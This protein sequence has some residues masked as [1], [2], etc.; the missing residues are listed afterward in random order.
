MISVAPHTLTS[1]HRDAS[2]GMLSVAMAA[3]GRT[4]MLSPS[5]NVRVV[6]H[7]QVGAESRRRHAQQ[8][9]KLK[10][11]GCGVSVLVQAPLLT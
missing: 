10:P 8:Q 5:T 11:L 3:M 6:A 2:F 4:L 9:Q 1:P 7:A